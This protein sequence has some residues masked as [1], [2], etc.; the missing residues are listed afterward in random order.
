MLRRMKDTSLDGLPK[1]YHHDAE[2]LMSKIQADA[3]MQIL[4]EAKKWIDSLKTYVDNINELKNKFYKW[5]AGKSDYD[6]LVQIEQY[7]NQFHIQLINLHD[8]KH[9]IRLYMNECKLHPDADHTA[10]HQ[11]LEEQY[12]FLIND[13]DH[14][15]NNFTAFISN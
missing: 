3:Y 7:H 11:D 12:N 1:I 6:V 5:A 13:L 4:D 10:K 2:E 8:L 9:S 15:K 14:L